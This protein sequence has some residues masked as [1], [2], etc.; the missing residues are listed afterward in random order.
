MQNGVLYAVLNSPPLATELYTA[1]TA[2]NWQDAR[3][4]TSERERNGICPH[5]RGNKSHNSERF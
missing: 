4:M 2:T 3:R 5:L 1:I